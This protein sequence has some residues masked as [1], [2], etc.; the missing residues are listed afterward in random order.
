M[1]WNHDKMQLAE[2]VDE[3]RMKFQRNSMGSSSK[4]TEKFDLF[5]KLHELYNELS[6]DES[7]Q[8]SNVSGILFIQNCTKFNNQTKFYHYFMST[9]SK[10]LKL[11][12]IYWRSYWRTIISIH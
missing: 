1:T 5:K 8:S 11:H 10:A 4:S 6:R 12:H 7:S 9:C 3:S 2:S